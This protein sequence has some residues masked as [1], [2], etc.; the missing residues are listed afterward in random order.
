MDKEETIWEEL[1]RFIGSIKD[2]I[3]SDEP[4]E[5]AIDFWL[6]KIERRVNILKEHMEKNNVKEQYDRAMAYV[7]N[8]VSPVAR[9]AAQQA[10]KIAAGYE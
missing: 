4:D 1:D 2:E 10:A 5:S 9:G 3:R 7:C 8:I 6:F